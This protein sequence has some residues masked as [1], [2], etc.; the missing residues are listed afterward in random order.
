MTATERQT[1]LI[2]LTAAELHAILDR[3]A[4]A[5]DFALGHASKECLAHV[6]LNAEAHTAILHQKHASNAL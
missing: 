6:I 5:T 4:E 1:A 2:Q 3:Y